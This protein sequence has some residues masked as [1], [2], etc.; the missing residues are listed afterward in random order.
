MS[1]Q[2][3]LLLLF[4]LVV[5][6]PILAV[7]M[8]LFSITADGE[9]GKADARLANGLRAAFGL[10]GDA[11]DAAG[12]ELRSV[13][14]DHRLATALATGDAALART[15]LA[16]LAAA[17][18]AI[19]SISLYRI[20]GRPLAQVGEGEGVAAAAAV[21][22]LPERGRVGV[23]AVSVTGAQQLARRVERFTGLEA[24][25][26]RHGEVLGSTL[27][28][29]GG[30]APGA[31]QL[32]IGGTS[33]RGRAAEVPEV[34]GPPVVLA[35]YDESGELVASIWRG[36]FF[37]AGLLLA[38]V[39]AALLSAQRVLRPIQ[40]PADELTPSAAA[41]ARD[42]AGDEAGVERDRELPG[43]DADGSGPPPDEL[44]PS[45]EGDELGRTIRLVGDAF[46]T[47]LDRQGTID[48]AVR[49]AVEACSAEAGRA[50]PAEHAAVTQTSA[51]ST[52][53]ELA[54]GLRAAEDAMRV[55]L[56][57][58]RAEVDGEG[59]DRSPVVETRT[60]TV[61]AL[62]VTIIARLGA[63]AR[64]RP[65]ATMSI[66]RG[67][68]QFSL[69]ESEILGY[70][71]G[72][73][74]VSIENASLH[75]TVQLQALTDEL[76][77]LHNA[78]QFH[79]T[80]VAEI[81]RSHRFRHDVG[82]VLLDLDDF[83][84]I[85]D[86]YGHQQGDRVLVEVAR[87]IERHLRDIDEVA[88]YGGEE[89]AVVLP[90]ADSEGAARGAERLRRAIAEIEAPVIAGTGTISLTA[91]FGVASLLDS[92]TDKDGLIAAADAAL[93]RAKRG[94]KD[95]VERAERV[96]MPR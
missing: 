33:Y 13:T 58:L 31:D 94:G 35:V 68:P 17:D 84:R 41:P 73:A 93:Y 55:R 61:H 24:R 5:V 88:R 23:V 40:R 6:A 54:A 90:Q 64:P 91:S 11:R 28:G 39:L 37:V 10:Y 70:L 4:L 20:D 26:G 83:K 43:G 19:V 75:E 18:P 7:A 9:T 95:R 77:G 3:R 48:V 51:G 50:A 56:E 96:A 82:L 15:L 92:A 45:R 89:F 12:D 16:R 72:Q 2:R 25:V 78:R 86:T 65:V 85:N 53:P 71:A 69:A 1:F 87:A 62:A 21:L 44:V 60:G 8:V 57:Q 27:P 63:S 36:R 47:G 42:G 32:E 30:V 38:L 79:R 76:T 22:T 59:P 74:G 81:D 29:A 80:L 66:A 49:T 34:A 46:A 67:E 14:A 52:D